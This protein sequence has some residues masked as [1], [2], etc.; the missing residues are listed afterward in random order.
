MQWF[1]KVKLVQKEKYMNGFYVTLYL[2]RKQTKE[3]RVPKQDYSTQNYTN[4]QEVER[5]F[6]K[7]KAKNKYNVYLSR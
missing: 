5:T 3:I 2:H 1:A 6:Y 7:L 4:K